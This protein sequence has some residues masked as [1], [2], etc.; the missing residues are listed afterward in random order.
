VRHPIAQ[1]NSSIEVAQ[2]A[3]KDDERVAPYLANAALGSQQVWNLVERASRATDAEAFVRRGQP[4]WTDLVPL[5]ADA[6]DAFRQTNSGNHFRL[7]SPSRVVVNADP[8]L[9]REAI[10]NL[11]G[12][13]ASFADEGSTIDIALAIDGFHTTVRVTNKG[14]LVEGNSEALVGPF[15]STRAGPSSEHHGLGL[16]LVR[17]IAEQHG[18]TATI[19]N[20]D[21]GS[22]VQAS[23]ELPCPML[24]RPSDSR[25]RVQ[26]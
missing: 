4:Q 26:P 19:A 21:D 24:R 8:I 7:E 20:L 10:D 17:L 13:A 3:S 18:G 15:A 11:L 6:L 14:P 12:N 25:G 22:G 9:I 2:L 23:I 5:I 16:Y 1:I